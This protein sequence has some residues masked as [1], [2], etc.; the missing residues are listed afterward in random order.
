MQWYS[1]NNIIIIVI[2]CNVPPNRQVSNSLTTQPGRLEVKEFS[3]ALSTPSISVIFLFA[4]NPLKGQ[5]SDSQRS[6][7]RD[8]NYLTPQLHAA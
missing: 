5:I 3:V 1:L 4:M 8:R 7:I 2:Y 6:N